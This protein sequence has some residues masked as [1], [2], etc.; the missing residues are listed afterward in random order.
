LGGREGGRE[1]GTWRKG[2]VR[3]RVVP[4]CS[5]GSQRDAIFADGCGEAW[6]E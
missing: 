3:L 5:I 6:G 2:A 1:G 4:Q